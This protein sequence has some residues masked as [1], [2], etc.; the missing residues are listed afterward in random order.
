MVCIVRLFCVIQIMMLSSAAGQQSA[1]SADLESTWLQAWRLVARNITSSATCRSACYLM[2]VVLGK[3]LIKYPDISDLIDSILSSVDLNGPVD[4]VDSALELWSVLLVLIS[5]EKT[6]SVYDTSERVIRWF[7]NRWKPGK[8]FALLHTYVT[9]WLLAKIQDRYHSSRLA[10]Q[11]GIQSMFAL[12]AVCLGFTKK[13]DLPMRPVLHLDPIAQ[14]RLK[15]LDEAEVVRYLALEICQVQRPFSHE[16]ATLLDSFE[17]SLSTAQFSVLNAIVFDMLEAEVHSMVENSFRAPMNVYNITSDVS[18]AATAL[19]VTGYALLSHPRVAEDRRAKD[20]RSCL[21]ELRSQLMQSILLANE[22]QDLVIGLLDSIGPCLGSA[23]QLSKDRNELATGAL[24]MT[25]AFDQRFWQQIR[26]HE[27]QASFHEDNVMEVDDGFESQMS[28]STIK[29]VTTT[30]SHD[31][32]TANTDLSAYKNSLSAKI[33]FMSTVGCSTDADGP[34]IPASFVGYL[35]ELHPHDFLACRPF[36][37]DLFQSEASIAHDDAN[38]VLEYLGRELLRCYE[39]ERCEVAMGLCLDIMTGLADSWTIAEA[40]DISDTGSSLYEWFIKIALS[41]GIS[42]PHVY[43][44]ISSMLQR[45]IK[46]RPEY[47]RSLS[48]PSARTSLFRV[49]EE[50]NI[51]VKFRVGKNISEIFG[52]FVLK[53][54]D[55]ILEDIVDSLPSDSGWL[56]GIA[57]RLFVLAHLAS[58]WPTLLRRCVYA[59]FET[60]GQISESTAHARFCLDHISRVLALNSSK[61]LFKLFSSQIIYTWLETQSFRNIPFAIFGYTCLAELLRDV[62][63]EI[64]G[65]IVMRGKDEEAT[66]LAQDLQT[67]YDTLLEHS[68][69]K[70]AAYSIA[71]DIA[72]PPSQNT[73][74]PG[75]DTRLRKSLGK[76]R[77]TTLMSLKFP[78]ILSVLYKA[79]DRE[80]NIEKGFQRHAASRASLARYQEIFSISASS[81]MLPANQQPSFKASFLVDEIERLCQRTNYQIEIIWT[82]SLYVYTLRGLL[83]SIHPA[84]GPLHACSIVRKVRILVCMAGEV[85]LDNYPLEMTLHSLRP[86]LT[87]TNC[88]EDTIGVVQYLLQ[89]GLPYLKN[90]PSFLAGMVICT[91]A[92]MK[93][94]LNTRQESTTQESQFKATMSKSNTFRLWLGTFLEGYRSPVITGF[95]D[96]SFRA[97]IRAARNI[98]TFGNS[99]RGTPESDLLLEIMEDE[100]SARH[101]LNRQSQDLILGMLCAKFEASTELSDNILASDREAAMYAPIVWHFCRRNTYGEGFRLWAARILGRAFAGTGHIDR[102]MLTEANISDDHN[103]NLEQNTAFASSSRSLILRTLVQFLYVDNRLHMGMAEMTI[104]S[105]IAK[106]VKK[107]DQLELEQCLPMSLIKA[108]T[109]DQYALPTRQHIPHNIPSIQ[110]SAALTYDV[111]ASQWTQSLTIALAHSANDDPVLS[112]LLPVL[113]SIEGFAERVFPFILHIVLLR[114]TDRHW[115]CRQLISEACR[116]WF[117]SCDETTV[118]HTRILLEA[119]LYLR[120]QPLPYE[121]SKA[122]R[123]QW[124]DVDYMKAAKAAAT[125][126]M[127]RTALLFIEINRSDAAKAS[128]RSSGIKQDEPTDLLL[129]LFQSIDEPDSFYG[130]QQPSSLSAMMT[131]L[132]Y[133]DA[134]FKSLSFRGAHYDSRIRHLKRA[135]GM[136]EERL[137]RILD[138]LDLNGLSQSLLGNIAGT[139]PKSIDS[140]MRTARKLEQWDISAPTTSISCE[141]TIFRTFQGVN[142]A[143]DSVS[144]RSSINMGLSAAL[145]SLVQGRSSEKYMHTALRTLAVLAEGDELLSS[146]NTEQLQD[147]WIHITLRDEWLKSGR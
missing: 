72:V 102:R 17:P 9:N 25:Q 38:A 76:D 132:E 140:M 71:R 54:H 13:S 26:S 98:R 18:Y 47:A 58:S 6:C 73:Q 83:N 49:L 34:T 95:S 118:P 69:A 105:I 65:Q 123:S 60:P 138:N 127:H 68:F 53:E 22:S 115:T 19:C 101:L 15:S 12:L 11:C 31:A 62:Q 85:A 111:S 48:L 39:L 4:C 139:G 80:E 45:V 106:A 55:A 93:A 84:L 141:H 104:Q 56:E 137:V 46:V 135:D 133:E 23:T 50:G 51:V 20:L 5:K 97:M 27:T 126:H 92:S 109:W 87:D 14:A 21:E 147:A 121:A 136:D 144:L 29:C 108:L 122:D 99:T 3:A 33:C 91:L 107:E 90:A 77:H 75:A 40:G 61:E 100:R 112:E 125:C 129:Q 1:H 124:L 142:N 116:H 120:R 30:I 64:T 78:E 59:I 146:I 32:V 94:F 43:V 28:H 70:A 130:L 66:Q 16:V 134:G 10:Q 96:T 42:S 7:F 86:L 131:R 52:L 103:L 37:R 88:A 74:A 57:L 36:L 119:I 128:R 41:R 79:I 145:L 110:D 2:M 24:T 81:M 82:P 89:N 44:G 35:T 113:S 114:E 63:D 117:G 8:P 143:T 67:P